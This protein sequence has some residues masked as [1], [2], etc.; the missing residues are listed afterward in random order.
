MTEHANRPSAGTTSTIEEHIVRVRRRL[1]QALAAAGRAPDA[2][3]LLAVSKTQPAAALRAA[4]EAGQC[5]FGENYLQEALEKQQALADLD[6]EWHFIGGIQSNK[7]REIAEHF[8]WAHTVDREKIARRLNDQRPASR[9]PLNICLQVN[10]DRE[11]GKA[12][13]D[14]EALPALAES[15][16]TLPGL[17]LRGLMAIPAASEDRDT[18]RRAFQRL[19]EA[20]TRLQER[21]PEAPLDTLSMGMSADLEAAV[22]EGATLVRIGSAIF[23]PRTTS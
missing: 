10:V 12:G 9:A 1:E 15:V 11:T 5:A 17:S 18:Q 23:G 6:P 20:L 2:A 19:A 16:L 8:D 3:R 4:H 21:F 7:T 13:T 14:F 22:L